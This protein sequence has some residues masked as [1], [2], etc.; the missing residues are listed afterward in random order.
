MRSRLAL[1]LVLVS[2][3]PACGGGAS[4]DTPDGAGGGDAPPGVD[5]TPVDIDPTP[6]LDRTPAS[7][8]ATCATAS[9]V[10]T[11]GSDWAGTTLVPGAG[12]LQV[13]YAQSAFGDAGV[14]VRSLSLEP[15]ALGA[16]VWGFEDANAIGRVSTARGAG[17][18]A[19][20]W[21]DS[22]GEAMAVKLVILDAA[23]APIGAVRTVPGLAVTYGQDVRVVALADGWALVWVDGDYA[24]GHLT[25][26]RLDAEGAPVGERVAHGPARDLGEILP[27]AD[28]GL[29]IGFAV[30]DYYSSVAQVV[31]LD[32]ALAEV[33]PASTISPGAGAHLGF[34]P[35]ALVADGTGWLAAYGE[36]QSSATFDEQADRESIQL[37]HLDDAGRR[38]GAVHRLV[39]PVEDV[40]ITAPKLVAVGDR[41]GLA[42]SAGSIIYFCGGCMPDH[43]MRFALLERDTLVPA[44]NVVETAG[45]SGLFTTSLVNVG[46]AIVGT[47]SV[48]YHVTADGAGALLSCE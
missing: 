28:G 4:D 5:A 35:P 16:E 39:A 19:V 2:L 46:D 3:V 25:T 32:D 27:G 36:R 40:S 34:G 21:L 17:T 41:V 26:L 23:G 48:T 22:A 44:S 15:L 6:I 8:P 47:F 11:F 7:S 24:S 43:V 20:A 42:W 10:T 13:A 12:P 29:V 1:A 33:A 31:V 37:V 18:T 9:T 14:H 38:V 45:N 30:G